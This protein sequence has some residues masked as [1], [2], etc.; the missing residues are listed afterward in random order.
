MGM[1]LKTTAAAGALLITFLTAAAPALQGQQRP[2][3]TES[4]DGRREI[5]FSGT[6]RQIEQAFMTEIH[7]F[8]FNGEIHVANARDISVPQALAGIVRG[9][10][11]LHDFVSKPKLQR[12]Q[13]VPNFT[14]GGRHAM[15]SYDFAVIF[16]LAPPSN[17]GFDGTGQTLA[18][19]GP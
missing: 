9:V 5:E 17:Q 16:A 15:V 6:A 18:I 13:S 7:R 8:D 19:A 11:S 4:V 2:R 3:I 1:T 14:F 10:V 12:F